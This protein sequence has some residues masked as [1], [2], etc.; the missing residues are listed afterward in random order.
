[1]TVFSQL[2]L[3]FKPFCVFQVYRKSNHPQGVAGNAQKY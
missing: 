2:N 3:L 1:M